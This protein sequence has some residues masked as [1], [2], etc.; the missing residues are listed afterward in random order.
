[1]EHMGIVFQNELRF[2]DMHV[3]ILASIGAPNWAVKAIFFLR[4]FVSSEHLQGGSDP[5]KNTAGLTKV[6]LGGG[7]Y[8]RKKHEEASA[9]GWSY[10]V[11][12]VIML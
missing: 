8:G 9:L 3:F 1:M 10:L 2:R 12:T 6:I 4:F 5:R 11:E 7:G